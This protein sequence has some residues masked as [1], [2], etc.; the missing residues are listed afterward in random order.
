[1][2]MLLLQD[3]KLYYLCT[4][5]VCFIFGIG[6]C[7][8]QGN[9]IT[10]YIYHGT[11]VLPGEF[12]A[13]G[14]TGGCT[15]TLISDNLVLAA[16]HCFCHRDTNNQLICDKRAVFTLHD[17]FPVDNPNTPID[18]SQI[19]QDVSIAGNV[20][21]H[22]EFEMRGWQREDLAVIEL[23]QPASSVSKVKPI[24]VE[25]PYKTPM[26]EDILTLVGYCG[27]KT[28]AD[29]PVESSSWGGISFSNQNTNNIHSCPGDSGGPILN[30]AQHVVG[31]ASWFDQDHS[32][33]RP[34]SYSYNWIFGLPSPGWGTCSW[35][36]IGPQK[37]HQSDP[38]WCPGGSFI[39]ALD[40]DACGDCN[41]WDS[42]VIGQA[43][44]C[45]LAGA[46]SNGW[47]SCSWVKVGPLNSH[48]PLP[49]WCPEG[50]FITALDLDACGDCNSWDSPVIGQVRCCKLAGYKNW[51][52]SYWKGVE[53]EGINSHQPGTPWCLEGAFI[54]QFDLDADTSLS[55][56][57]SPIVGQ[58]KCS[59][60]LT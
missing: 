49:A 8:A 22:P 35:V 34:T 53:R 15:A 3:I 42:P 47:D 52:S 58:A 51:G 17:V 11:S 44:C 27:G 32:V 41:P 36:K 19:R 7:G 46:E 2:N 39:T 40:L 12:E 59:R 25:Y 26:A 1:M 9:N 50:S 4:L 6:I 13:V 16:A 30:S 5:I 54:T 33:Y 55:D 10:T 29:L 38:N 60:P 20:R 45:K 23:D 21:I 28:K 18:E 57:D 24:D 14:T 48:Q 43:L 37:S 31:V 56:H